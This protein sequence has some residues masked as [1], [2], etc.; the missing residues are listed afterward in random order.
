VHRLVLNLS[1]RTHAAL[2]KQAAAARRTPA[3]QVLTIV[4]IVLGLRPAGDLAAPWDGPAAGP[5]T[6]P[7]DGPPAPG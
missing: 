4:E 6:S 3:D 7:R 2:V 1:E 5:V